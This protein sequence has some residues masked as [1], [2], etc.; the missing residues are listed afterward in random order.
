[1]LTYIERK[2]PQGVR[3]VQARLQAVI[4]LLLQY[5]RTGRLTGKRGKRR[6]VA[7]PDPY[8]IFYEIIDD[9]IVIHSMRHTAR[10]PSSMP[11]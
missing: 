1:V 6:V 10:R 11:E 4:N 2:S 7:S 8:L 3:R 9:E 5:P